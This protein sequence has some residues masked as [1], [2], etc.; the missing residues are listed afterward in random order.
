MAKHVSITR[1]KPKCV[2]GK[3]ATSSTDAGHGLELHLCDDCR[4]AISD[5]IPLRLQV[6]AK[7]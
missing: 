7:K 5:G 2:C 3:K 6:G 4:G 1:I